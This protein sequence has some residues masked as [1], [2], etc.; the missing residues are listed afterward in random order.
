MPKM[1][2]PVSS[3]PAISVREVILL[4][5]LVIAGLSWFKEYESANKTRS[6]LEMVKQRFR[7]M[8]EAEADL[9]QHPE[10]KVTRLNITE[11]GGPQPNL[12][13]TMELRLLDDPDSTLPTGDTAAPPPAKAS[14]P[15]PWA[16]DTASPLDDD[17]PQPVVG[18]ATRPAGGK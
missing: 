5:A 6:E 17:R 14:A 15:P 4:T 9:R 8:L 16:K 12:R 3:R 10:N 2:R 1:L 13:W 7:T 11:V 18:G